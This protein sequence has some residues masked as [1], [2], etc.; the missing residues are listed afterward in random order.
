MSREDTDRAV[1]ADPATPPDQLARMLA[2][3]SSHAVR[4]L[5]LRNP[6]LP[7][8]LALEARLRGEAHIWFNPQATLLSLSHPP[9]REE[10][11]RG[12]QSLIAGTEPESA[13]FLR[14]SFAPWG[15][16][17]WENEVDPERYFHL[18]RTLSQ[19]LEPEG[20]VWMAE[21]TLAVLGLHG[22][23]PHAEGVLLDWLTSRDDDALESAFKDLEGHPNDLARRA[24]K[25]AT[26]PMDIAGWSYFLSLASGERY[27]GEYDMVRGRAL[28]QKYGSTVTPAREQEQEQRKR[29][30]SEAIRATVP[31]ER[32]EPYVI[33]EK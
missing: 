27:K 33:G 1:A 6:N 29:M 15:A 10:V 7:E 2:S 3:P 21:A 11:W 18:F 12:M 28:S 8:H 31:W 26:F 25:A 30:V 4:G 20:R 13:A 16:E 22:S 9:S 5:V 23:Y 14:E 32:V 24:V 17:A 19:R